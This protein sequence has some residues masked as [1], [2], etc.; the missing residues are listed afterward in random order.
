M[1]MRFFFAIIL[2]GSIACQPSKPA[3][4]NASPIN[5]E[6]MEKKGFELYQKEPSEALP[7]FKAAA[8]EYEKRKDIKKAGFTNL[9]IANIYDEHL[10]QID[11]ALKFAHH[12]LKVWTSAN[13]TLQMANLYKY[14]GLLEAKNGSY[15]QAES[16][17]LQ[18]IDFYTSKGH[19]QGIAV[20]H[21]NLAETYFR[22]KDYQKSLEYFRLSKDFWLNKEDKR[23]MYTDNILGIKLHRALEETSAANTLIEEN[24]TIENEIDIHD[25]PKALFRELLQEAEG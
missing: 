19:A 3:G 8:L 2:I 6:E 15:D 14:I 17:I 10:S 24:L 18:A 7:Y 25:Y 13:D 22:K 20:S 4:E 12:S 5:L 23:R 21:I 9:N 16:T 1:S 11:S